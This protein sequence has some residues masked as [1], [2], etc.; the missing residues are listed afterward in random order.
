MIGH[1]DGRSR[2]HA[3]T[4]QLIQEVAN[5]CRPQSVVHVGG[6]RVVETAAPRDGVEGRRVRKPEGTADP[7]GARVHSGVA[8]GRIQGGDV[9]PRVGAGGSSFLV[10]VVGRSPGRKQGQPIR[11]R[12]AGELFG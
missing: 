8:L 12:V 2:R 5:R 10:G 3:R 11:H 6:G 1:I 9:Q 7:G 4:H